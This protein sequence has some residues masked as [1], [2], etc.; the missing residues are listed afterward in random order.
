MWRRSDSSDDAVPLARSRSAA[1]DAILPC[2]A[3][4]SAS[5]A[6]ARRQPLDCISELEGRLEPA[7]AGAGELAVA[8]AGGAI[9]GEP[10]GAVGFLPN[11]P[12]A[13]D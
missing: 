2:N 1:P 5:A 8:V 11:I 6:E 9:A 7:G 10:L 3:A 4:A 12:M 13:K